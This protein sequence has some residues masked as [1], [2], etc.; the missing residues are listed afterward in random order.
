MQVSSKRCWV[1]PD[2]GHPTA[3]HVVVQIM[4]QHAVPR[5][6]LYDIIN[7]AEVQRCILSNAPLNKGGIRFMAE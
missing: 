3:L 1:K 7:I 6:V 5:D 2:C 4:N